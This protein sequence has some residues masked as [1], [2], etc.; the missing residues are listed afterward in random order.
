MVELFG[1]LLIEYQTHLSVRNNVCN[2]YIE[3]HQGSTIHY[4]VVHRLFVE[5]FSRNSITSR[6]FKSALNIVDDLR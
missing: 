1:L 3:L 6:Y 4:K 2:G 5:D